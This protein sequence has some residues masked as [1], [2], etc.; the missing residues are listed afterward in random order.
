[1]VNTENSINYLEQQSNRNKGGETHPT[2][3]CSE[4]DAVKKKQKT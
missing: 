4:P 3:F 1:M 2:S